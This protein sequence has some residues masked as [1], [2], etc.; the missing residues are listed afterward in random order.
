MKTYKVHCVGHLPETVVADGVIINNGF[1]G[2][3]A[4][5][6][7]RYKYETSR[8]FKRTKR[9]YEYEVVKAYHTG[10]WTKVEEDSDS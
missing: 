8:F 1:G 9:L 7:V 5:L 4:L 3:G 6:L 10:T 2:G